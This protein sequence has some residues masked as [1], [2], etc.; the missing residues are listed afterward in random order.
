MSGSNTE[1]PRRLKLQAVGMVLL[2]VLLGIPW[3]IHVA[4]AEG[5]AAA[6]FWITGFLSAVAVSGSVLLFSLNENG[7]ADTERCTVRRI[8]PDLGIANTLTM[9]RSYAVSVLFATALIPVRSELLIWAPF[10]L[11]TL[12]ITIDFFDGFVARVTDRSSKLGETLEHEFDS[13]GL[14][15]ATLLAAARG[16]LSWWFMLP[17]LYR[18][19]FMYAY[20][21]RES[22]GLPVTEP[23]NGGAG[24]V[25]AGLY[26]GFI[27]TSLIP[28]FPV[29]LLHLGAP[30]FVV[31]LTGA[32]LRD[33]YIVTGRL[34]PGS[35]IYK[36][37]AHI[38]RVYIFGW[39]PL[40]AR[41]TS[42]VLIGS[43]APSI[44]GAP[45]IILYIAVAGLTLGAFART[46]SILAIA[47]LSFALVYRDIGEAG[48]VQIV[49][50]LN[51]LIIMVGSGRFS[52]ARH[53]DI[54]FASRIGG[55]V[56]AHS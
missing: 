9:T 2:H 7:T 34:V 30:F 15:S 36:L 31:P 43:L 37:L 23:D 5:M 4:T 51:C 10:F 45:S 35:G 12:S 17:A 21:R 26:W 50:A 56:E 32:F 49:V 20:W 16:S 28:V 13:I 53:E 25:I 52:L 48:L 41:I 47:V 19:I 1:I 54:P 27:A 3:A 29:Q 42:A 14:I 55:R 8:R 6:G 18:Y 11:Y 44:G 24:R 33:W 46:N 39:I 40:V 22:Q 38:L